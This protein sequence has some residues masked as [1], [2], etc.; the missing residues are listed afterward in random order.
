MITEIPSAAAKVTV[1]LLILCVRQKFWLAGL[2]T[3]GGKQVYG[4]R[5]AKLTDSK[6]CTVSRKKSRAR[7]SL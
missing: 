6:E 5:S 7:V 4:I 1:L 3:Q 2:S